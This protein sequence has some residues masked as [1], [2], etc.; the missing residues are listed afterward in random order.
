LKGLCISCLGE[1]TDLDEAWL[2]AA[3]AGREEVQI[4]AADDLAFTGI[5]VPAP[6]AAMCPRCAS[7][8]RV[9]AVPESIA[10]KVRRYRA[11]GR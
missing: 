5:V 2:R 6:G 7:N 3:T 10:G 1:R 8:S 9:V 4:E 11:L